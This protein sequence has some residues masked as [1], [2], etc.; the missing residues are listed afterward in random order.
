MA[1]DVWIGYPTHNGKGPAV[2][3]TPGAYY[4]FLN[5]LFED[6]EEQHGTMI[7]PYDGAA[8]E[9]EELGPVLELV[10]RA[11]RLVE[12]QPAV[13]DV[14]MGT[15]IGSYLEPKN[16]PVYHRVER[17]AYLEF[18]ERLRAAVLAAQREHLPL[19][20]YGD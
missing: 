11:R 15:N 2:S 9:G 16:E 1:L 5:P 19:V 10:D 13:F 8:F 4:T 20:F 6:F 7:D 12:E 14:F 3:F 17:A 18:L